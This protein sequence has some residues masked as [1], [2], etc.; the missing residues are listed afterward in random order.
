MFNMSSIDFNKCMVLFD[1]QNE[2]GIFKFTKEQVEYI[3][4][5]LDNYLVLKL[6][7]IYYGVTN[8]GELEEYTRKYFNC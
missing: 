1:K 2:E 6:T 3:N 4:S 8:I 7:L 5:C